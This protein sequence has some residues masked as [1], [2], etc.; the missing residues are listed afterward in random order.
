[1]SDNAMPVMRIRP[2]LN[3]VDVLVR[4]IDAREKRSVVT[5]TGTKDMSEA[6]VG[7]ESGRVRLVLWGDKAGSL[8]KGQPVLIKNAFVTEFH[9]QLQL[10]AG[11][12]SAVLEAND[13]AVPDENSIPKVEPRHSKSEGYR[14]G[15]RGSSFR[16]WHSRGY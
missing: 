5:S 6:M 3:H 13:S 7:D 4:V 10:N 12:Y 9:G 11:E 2:G 14:R 8:K 1:M 16:H 15:P